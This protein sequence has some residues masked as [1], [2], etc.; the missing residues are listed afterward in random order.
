MPNCLEKFLLVRR[1]HYKVLSYRGLGHAASRLQVTCLCWTQC[2]G[3]KKLG[4]SLCFLISLGRAGLQRPA[5]GIYRSTYSICRSKESTPFP[6]SSIFKMPLVIKSTR[7]H[8]DPLLGFFR[9]AAR[10]SGLVLSLLS[11]LRYKGYRSNPL[12]KLGVTHY[13]CW[14]RLSAA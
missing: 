13:C 12:N 9:D 14:I 5:R 2:E 7:P 3:K 11:C 10:S 4:I 8:C 6:I 1:T